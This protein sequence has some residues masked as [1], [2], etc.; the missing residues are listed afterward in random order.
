MN[1][2]FELTAEHIKLLRRA[3]IGWQ[4]C[5]TGAPEIDPK[6]PYGNSD[7][8]RDVA[9]ILGLEGK[10]CPHCDGLLDEGEAERC[11]RLHRETEMALTILC[12][13]A[14]K[15]TPP[16]WYYREGGRYLHQQRWRRRA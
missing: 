5:E 7:V 4:D 2:E 1:S 11:E 3:Y 14:G 16:G 15:E 13:R 10:R 12:N 9:D 6:Q 8:G